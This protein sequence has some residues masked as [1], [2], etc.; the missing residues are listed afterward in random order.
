MIDLKRGEIDLGFDD[1]EF[2]AERAASDGAGTVRFDPAIH[3]ARSALAH[4][5]YAGSELIYVSFSSI[6]DQ[7]AWH[8]WLF[9][10]DL[11]AWK[12]GPSRDAISSVFVTTPELDCDNGAARQHCGGGLWG[13]SG[14]Q[15][16]HSSE[17]VEIIVQSGNG[18]L[19]LK[20]GN[21]AQS[22]LRLKPGLKFD[23]LCSPEQCTNIDPRNPPETCLR[24][25]KNLFVPRLLPTDQPLRPADGLCNGLTFLQCLDVEDWDF[26]SSSPVYVDLPNHQSIYVTVGKAGDVYVVDANT[27]G[28]M[29][30]RKQIAE[31][32]GTVE[33][34]CPDSGEGMIISQPQ[35]AWVEDSPIVVIA[36]HNPD[37]SHAAGI[38]GYAIVTQTGQPRLKKVWQVPSPS[39]PEA[40]RWFR[41]PPTRP[42]ISDFEG[43]L[44]AW[45]A[46]N[47]SEGRIVGVR[48]RDGK[49]VANVRTAGR[50]VRN[51]KPVLY[52]NVLYLPTAVPGRDGLTW[53]EAYR[54]SHRP[55]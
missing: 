7:G 15:I 46:D 30:D 36:T 38:V 12:R 8:G 34:P 43:E 2:S 47:A 13:Y 31:L 24:T 25:C 39:A 26:G 18:L 5:S 29:Y 48:I 19:N 28:I 6:G 17:G 11:G 52:Q 16:R 10:I 50:P 37:H 22:M 3:H 9:E 54:I 23:P 14:P 45:V 51:A 49:L 40:K 4:V 1:L 44:I 27:L 55:H 20:T 21:Y 32:C 53:I 33:E 41:A 42:I 35:V